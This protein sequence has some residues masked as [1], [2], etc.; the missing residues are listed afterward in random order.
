MLSIIGGGMMDYKK[1]CEEY[2]Q[3]SFDFCVQIIDEENNFQIVGNP[4]CT[5]C[6]EQDVCAQI[7]MERFSKLTGFQV[8]EFHLKMKKNS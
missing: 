4:R 2:T 6:F 8:E 7:I 3:E 5:Q 1:A